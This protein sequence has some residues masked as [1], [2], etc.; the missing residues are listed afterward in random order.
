VEGVSDGSPELW[1]R[2]QKNGHSW[3]PKT[4]VE[5]FWSFYPI[6]VAFFPLFVL[7]VTGGLYFFPMGKLKKGST[8]ARH[9]KEEVR[10]LKWSLQRC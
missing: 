2:R 8:E 5:Y 10:A 7:T 6:A 4:R 3:H 9:Q 1:E